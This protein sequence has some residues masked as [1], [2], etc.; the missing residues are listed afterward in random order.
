MS[1]FELMKLIF[2]TEMPKEVDKAVLGTIANFVDK[3]GKAWPSSETICRLSGRS[4][5]LVFKQ[6]KLLEALGII[7]R[8][9]VGYGRSNTY[10]FN[11]EAI[12]NSPP[13]GLLQSATRTI[14]SPPHGHKQ[15]I[16]QTIEQTMSGTSGGKVPT[17]DGVP[18]VE[19]ELEEA[20]WEPP[21]DAEIQERRNKWRR[22]NAAKVLSGYIPWNPRGCLED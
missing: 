15:T 19:P 8:K 20:D 14:N 6:I 11:C 4:R 18:E 10:T 5:D 21:T 22:S 13:H 16:E 12:T 2:S 1:S 17:G 7:N 3:D 9:Q